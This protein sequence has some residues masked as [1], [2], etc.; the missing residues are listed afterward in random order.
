[1]ANVIVPAEHQSAAKVT[2][3]QDVGIVGPDG[4]ILNKPTIQLD[5][6]DAALLREYRKFLERQGL[7]EALFCEKCWNRNLEDGTRAH[8]TPSSVMI[9]CRCRRL[10]FT[11]YTV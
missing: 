1:M 7:R 2:T 3:T 6:K 4:S 9:E 5:A 10:L 11:G 8:V